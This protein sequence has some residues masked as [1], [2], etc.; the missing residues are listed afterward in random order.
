MEYFAFGFVLS[1]LFAA[2]GIWLGVQLWPPRGADLPGLDQLA[3]MTNARNAENQALQ[4][5][6][7]QLQ[8]GLK[9]NVC[10]LDPQ[11]I[12]PLGT[13]NKQ[14]AVPPAAPAATPPPT[15]LLGPGGSG[16][17]Q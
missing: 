1:L 17:Q 15:P 12:A 6:I 16:P 14:A 4:D 13:V 11:K 10:K 5:R 8:A 2:I 3:G 9:G 7:D